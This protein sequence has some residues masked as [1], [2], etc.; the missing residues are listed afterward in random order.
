[1]IPER[2]ARSHKFVLT[3]L[4]KVLSR[5]PWEWWLALAAGGALTFFGGWG[6]RIT[7]G[8][9]GL[10]T[11]FA[12]A[13]TLYSSAKA[14]VE[15]LP[16]NLGGPTPLQLSE[17]VL[18]AAEE[19][20]RLLEA[21]FQPVFRF[22]RGQRLINGEVV[23]FLELW[24]DGSPVQSCDIR[25]RSCLIV[26]RSEN[27]AFS[28]RFIPAYY[29]FRRDYNGDAKVGLLVTLYAWRSGMGVSDDCNLTAELNR[30]K[31]EV[32]VTFR[33]GVSVQKAVFLDISY[34]DR[35]SK[36]RLTTFDIFSGLFGIGSPSPRRLSENLL[37]SMNLP[38]DLKGL[39]AGNI[40]SLW[41][42]PLVLDK[43]F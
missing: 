17:R 36:W 23:D 42:S 8:S 32:E 9:A 43:L 25:Q 21:H 1:M 3:I 26:S 27:G 29:F 14:K 12:I 20:N 35:V 34:E 30:L 11:A 28:E 7:M 19:H 24:N 15:P 38:Q 39:T 33:G 2:S 6:N 22:V 10:I 40:L 37:L 5:L 41:D 31:G 16:S 18:A 13:M 4:M